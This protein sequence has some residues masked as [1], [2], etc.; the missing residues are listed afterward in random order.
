MVERERASKRREEGR[1]RVRAIIVP[2]EEG[3]VQ[4]VNH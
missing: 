4:K 2:H 3:K 1:E